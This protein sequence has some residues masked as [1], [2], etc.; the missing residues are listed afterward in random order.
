MALELAINEDRIA[1][2]KAPLKEKGV[3]SEPKEREIKVSTT[4]LDSG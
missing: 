3:D 1:H 4:D 2:S